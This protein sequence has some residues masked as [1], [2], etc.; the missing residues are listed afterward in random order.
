ML[1]QGT[2][3]DKVSALSMIIQKDPMKSVTYL[4]T[5]INLAKK[6]NR[7]QG[8]AAIGA[9]KDLFINHGLLKDN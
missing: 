7:K 9:L 4:S 5:L 2:I 8:E 1:K 6:K 3:S